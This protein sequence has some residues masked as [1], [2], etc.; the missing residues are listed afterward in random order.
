M[1]DRE[2]ELIDLHEQYMEINNI[3]DDGALAKLWSDSPENRFFNLTGHNYSGLAEW[4]ELWRYYSTRF[5]TTEPWRSHNRRVQIWG[6]VGL[7]TCTRTWGVEWTGNEPPPIEPFP[8]YIHSRASEV[9]VY[10]EDGWQIVHVH[11]SAL[12][13]G[14]RP[15]DVGT[16]LA[17]D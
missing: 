15:G 4:Q 13:T 8:E 16:D 17:E 11:Y 6:D 10:G 9:A 1:T 3:Q 14:P 5:R 12:S 2:Q 7:L